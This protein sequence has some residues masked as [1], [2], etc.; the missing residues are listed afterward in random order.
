MSGIF[1]YSTIEL[2]SVTIAF[3]LMWLLSNSDHLI[4]TW[5]DGSSMRDKDNRNAIF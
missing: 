2:H 1:N 4:K 3:H 5:K